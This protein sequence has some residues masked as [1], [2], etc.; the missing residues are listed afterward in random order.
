MN[1]TV[2]RT[3]WST[4]FETASWSIIP[5]REASRIKSR[6]REHK[7]EEF[8]KSS[9]L[10]VQKFSVVKPGIYIRHLHPSFLKWTWMKS[11]SVCINRF[12]GRAQCFLSSSATAKAFAHAELTA[13]PPTEYCFQQ[14]KRA[15][16]FSTLSAAEPEPWCGL[17]RWDKSTTNRTSRRGTAIQLRFPITCWKFWPQEEYKTSLRFIALIFGAASAQMF[18]SAQP[19]PASAQKRSI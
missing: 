5:R 6:K 12:V 11:Q 2:Y 15:A 16:G 7:R 14:S 9:D 1:K 4:F 17:S 13:L 10:H 18:A 19:F 3:V 8:L